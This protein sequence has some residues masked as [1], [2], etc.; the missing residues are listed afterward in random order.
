MNGLLQD[1]RYAARQLRRH[2]AFT[3]VALITLALA[4]GANTA[5]FSVV[6]TVLLAP[7][8]YQQVDRLMM[9]WGRNTARGN[10]RFPASAGEFHD[11]KSNAVFDDI[12]A[13]YDDALTL[14]GAGE[15]RLVIGYRFTP[16]YFNILGVAPAM[17]R[18][19]T[20]EDARS[21]PN[22]VVLSDKFWRTALHSDPQIVGKSL[23]LD[24]KPFTVVGVMPPDFAYPPRT[25]MWLPVPFA[26]SGDYQHQH[27]FLRVIGRLKPGVSAAAAEAQMSALERQIS[28]LHPE[29][30]SGNEV[31]IEPV[32]HQLSG[33]IRTPLL[34]LLAAV[35]LVLLIACVNLANLLLARV[36]SRRSEISVRA[37]IGATRFRLIQQLLCESFLLSLLGGA[38]GLLLAR[39][40]TRFLLAIFPNGVANL[41][42]PRVDQIPIDSTVLLFSLATTVLTAA[43]FGALP[44][45]Q[46]SRANAQES[47]RD[48][49]RSTTSR[50]HATTR[51]ALVIS[52]VALSLLLLTGAGL[53]IESLRHVYQQ[54]LGFQP[55]P[56]VA[57]EVFLPSNRYPNEQPEKSQMFLSNVLDRLGKLP[58]VRSVAATNFL[59]LT[60]FWGTTYFTIEGQP[61]NDNAKP[62]AD[63]RLVTPGYFSTMGIS[64]L[65]GRSFTDADRAG[66]EPVAIISATLARHY[67]GGDD[68]LGRTID[69]GD[70]AHPQPWRIVGLVSDVKAFGPEQLA[71]AD[72]YRPLA[73]NSFRLLAFTLR[74]TGDP[75]ALLKTAEQ[76][77]W[78]VDKDQPIFDAMTMTSLASQSVTLR[79]TSTVLMGSFAGLALILAA[80]GLYGVMSYSVAQRTHE[81]GIRMA[82][83]AKHQD[84]LRL[85]LTNG[86]RLV[87][88]GE[89]IG[90]IAALALTRTATSLVYGVRPG[91][92]GILLAATGVLTLIALT[93]SFIPALRAS[94]VNPIQAL[95]CE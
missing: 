4:I 47:L 34:A 35:G 85:V 94:K 90:A 24:A 65:R 40:S 52:E 86:L 20:E 42:I 61:A 14:T 26:L 30:D 69:L 32:R 8:P 70:A 81:I 59:P 36:A 93:A 67:F 7:V 18:T 41:S 2:P 62:L 44:A 49:S 28:N 25:E 9:I 16:N 38:L 6:H 82:L 12:A 22:V 74:A 27:R 68:P 95:R 58:G 71:H 55:E 5:I 17:G 63:N 48:S 29:A 88:I 77:L 46:A 45:L 56:V 1:F 66:S 15:P 50:A 75:A 51:R 87:L 23:N 92:P 83:G 76:A 53:M 39:A 64:V 3:I 21:N 10:D 72:L 33:D 57:I 91:D 80:V 37:A 54:D 60:G 43:L 31:S 78:D 79:R 89:V 84:V 11:W 73:Q 19:F 13:S